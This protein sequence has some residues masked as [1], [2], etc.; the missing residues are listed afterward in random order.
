MYVKFDMKLEKMGS[1]GVDWEKKGVIG[2]KIG[3]IKGKID[4]H[5]ISTDI[6]EC[7]PRLLCH[8]TNG[9]CQVL[10]NISSAGPT[11]DVI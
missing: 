5:L 10:V 11:F 7:S 3:V 2:C 6:W 1:L 4:R 8:I 9:F